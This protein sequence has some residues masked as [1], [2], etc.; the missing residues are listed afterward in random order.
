LILATPNTWK[1]HVGK[2]NIG[3]LVWEGD[4][5]PESWV[6]E[7]LNPDIKYIICPSKHTYNAVLNTE[8][9]ND[10]VINKLVIIPH[11]VDTSLF[12]PKDKPTDKFRF[13]ANKGFRHLEDRGGVQYVIKSFIEEF[14]D[15][16]VELLVKI[17]PAYGIN[18]AIMP[19]HPKIK[20]ICDNIP[21]DKLINL[22]N[23]ANCFVSGTRAEAFNIPCVEAMACGLPCI[24]TNYGGQIDYVNNE[25]GWLVDYELTEVTFDLQYEG[26]NWATPKIDDLRKKMRY[27]YEH[28]DEVKEKGK[29]ALETAR[30]LTWQKTA[31]QIKQLISTT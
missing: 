28:Q 8:G 27:A 1:L 11:G 7:C 20:Y 15:E 26:I 2:N 12:Y 9:C 13:L 10:D 22:Y 30:G 17:N 21:Y 23:S 24:V 4:R 16:N 29:K 5:I 18:K 25:N 19:E 3:Y 6:E 14:K 31:E